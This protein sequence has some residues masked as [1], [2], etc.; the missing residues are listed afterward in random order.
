[1]P[2]RLPL[3]ALALLAVSAV[4]STAQAVGD[5]EAGATKAL[6]CTG[7]HAGT[8][9]RMNKPSIFRIPKVAGQ[10]NEYLVSALKDY[11]SGTRENE[12]MKAIA[13]ALSD[14]DIED[15]AAHFASLPWED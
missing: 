13:A 8:G 3:L 7:C 14:Q 9:L 1:M 4:H 10:H 15:L 11:K 6:I 5:P 2:A 12:S